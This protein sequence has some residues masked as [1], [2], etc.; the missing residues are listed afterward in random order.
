MNEKN[1]LAKLNEDYLYCTR[2]V[3]HIRSMSI[4]QTKVLR[5]RSD[6]EANIAF[7]PRNNPLKFISKV[8]HSFHLNEDFTQYEVAI[9][10]IFISKAIMQQ[11]KLATLCIVICGRQKSFVDTGQTNQVMYNSVKIKN[12][13][14]IKSLYI[15]PNNLIYFSVTKRLL[16]EIP[17]EIRFYSGVSRLNIDN[18][19]KNMFTIAN[20]IF[21]RKSAY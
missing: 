6:I 1:E 20:L 19:D 9:E 16:D 4:L 15:K 10:S 3:F 17:I 7:Y 11:V 21:R 8:Y 5:L 18:F 13:R 2:C 12:P 14:K